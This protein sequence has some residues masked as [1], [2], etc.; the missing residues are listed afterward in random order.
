MPRATK[1]RPTLSPVNLV[2][3]SE[4]PPPV[5]AWAIGK[6]QPAIEALA[7][8]EQIVG[9]VLDV[10]CGLGE[11]A[12]LLAS[13]GHMVWGIDWDQTLIQQARQQAQSQALEA[14]FVVGNALELDVLGEGFH[15]VIDS[16]LLHCLNDKERKRY[17]S[18]LAHVM[19]PGS[20]LFILCVSENEALSAA[21][22]YPLSRKELEKYFQSGWQIEKIEASLYC[23]CEQ[24]ASAWLV[25]VLK[26]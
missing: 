24:M 3:A 20:R 26:L 13:R 14:T 21:D 7:N 1:V 17:L 11:N 10:G 8:Q 15:T 9:D 19:F 12:L 22:V 2:S 4:S 25:S 18:G 6:P 23:L 16:G 5:C